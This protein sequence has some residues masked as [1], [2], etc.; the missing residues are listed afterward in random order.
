MEQFNPNAMTT[1][2]FA[3]YIREQGSESLKS[4]CEIILDWDNETK[5][6][7]EWLLYLSNTLSEHIDN[8]VATQSN[9]TQ[10]DLYERNLRN[11]RRY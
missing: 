7:V 10:G 8:L 3:K 6:L 1:G 11:T 2:D 5:P 9:Q 4:M